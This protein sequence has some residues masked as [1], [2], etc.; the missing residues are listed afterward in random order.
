MS[1]VRHRGGIIVVV[2]HRPSALASVDLLLVMAKGNAMSFG[3][4]DEVLP[5]VLAP[6]AVPRGS[7]R[8]VKA[9]KS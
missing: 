1:R 8:L 5:K 6:A 4:K 9:K 7:L 3:P 2:A